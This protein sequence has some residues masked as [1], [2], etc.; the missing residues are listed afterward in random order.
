[1]FPME[2]GKEAYCLL[3]SRIRQMNTTAIFNHPEGYPAVFGQKPSPLPELFDTDFHFGSRAIQQD[4]A[5][6][7]GQVEVGHRPCLVFFF[8]LHRW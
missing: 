3:G 8:R 4:D 2:L 1:M 7:F 6:T 5:T